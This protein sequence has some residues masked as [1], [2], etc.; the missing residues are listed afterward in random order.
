M[1]ILVL[2][3]LAAGCSLAADMQIVSDFQEENVRRINRDGRDCPEQVRIIERSELVP[4]GR[5]TPAG[6]PPEVT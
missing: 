5:T 3:L 1:K 2:L 6:R 4:K